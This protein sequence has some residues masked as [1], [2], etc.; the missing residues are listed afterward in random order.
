MAISAI[1][2]T[3]V[4]DTWPAVGNSVG[5]TINCHESREKKVLRL[6]KKFWPVLD[7]LRVRGHPGIDELCS[8][9][10]SEEV[11]SKKKSKL[12]N[13]AEEV[14][15]DEPV[16]K[17]Q[18]IRNYSSDSIPKLRNYSVTLLVR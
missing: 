11:L 13:F 6:L 17:S 9:D 16:P 15:D 18:M 3:Q 4:S 10:K 12:K 7:V 8:N 1:H 14:A 2:G 5:I